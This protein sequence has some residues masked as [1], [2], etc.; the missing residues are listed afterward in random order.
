VDLH[1]MLRALF[2]HFDA[3]L[4]KPAQIFVVLNFGVSSTFTYRFAAA[5]TFSRV[6]IALPSQLA[7][8]ALTY[9]LPLRPLAPSQISRNDPELCVFQS[10]CQITSK[11]CCVAPQPQTEPAT[12]L[13]LL[14]HAPL[15]LNARELVHDTQAHP[16]NKNGAI[17]RAPKFNFNSS[18]NNPNIVP[19][20]TLDP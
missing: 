6:L 11:L 17:Q 12:C 15:R 1:L 4:R 14:T 20:L 19:T 5:E 8:R 13:P 7:Q 9:T 18:N 2:P 16:S 10:Q 3:S